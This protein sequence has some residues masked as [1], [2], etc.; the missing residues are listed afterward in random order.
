M[1]MKKLI[2]FI[3]VLL[4]CLPLLSLAGPVCGEKHYQAERFQALQTKR[5]D[6]YRFDITKPP[7]YAKN[8]KVYENVKNGEG[9]TGD[10]FVLVTDSQDK[11]VF[12]KRMYLPNYFVNL[13]EANIKH[14]EKVDVVIMQHSGGISCCE[15]FHLFQTKPTFK[16]LGTQ[17]AY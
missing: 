9:C 14:P 12:F 8:S 15:Y 17:D 16:Y 11:V 4:L 6:G 5:V 10:S 3:A 7:A 2:F 1:V 13:D